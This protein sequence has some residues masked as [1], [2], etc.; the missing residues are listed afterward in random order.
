MKIRLGELKKMTENL[1][2]MNEKIFP[3][4]ISYA[5][6]RNIEVLEKE[7]LVFDRQRIEICKHYAEKDEKGN[8][9]TKTNPEDGKTVYSIPDDAITAF[10][11]ELNEL[12]NEEVDIG[13]R[14]VDITEFEKCEQ[15]DRYDFPTGEDFA[16]LGFM[17]DG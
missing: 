15:T 13:I 8:P 3:V 2:L 12:S 16:V 11:D 5:I 17:I 14:K 7:F 9:V 4:K 6:T 10:N 1:H